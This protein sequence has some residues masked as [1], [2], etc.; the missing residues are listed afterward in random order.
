MEA[1]VLKSYEGPGVSTFSTSEIVNDL[2]FFGRA[3]DSE[4]APSKTSWRVRSR[5]LKM[6]TNVVLPRE[7]VCQ[8]PLP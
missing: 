5:N 2:Q 4:L 1:D 8:T 3:V 6:I 7:S